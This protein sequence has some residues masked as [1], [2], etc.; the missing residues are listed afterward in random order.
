MKMRLKLLVKHC[1]WFVPLGLAVFVLWSDRHIETC[2]GT[3]TYTTVEALPEK[4]VA[5][6]LGTA[7]TYHG[8]GNLFYSA[9][10]KAA[11][12]LYTCGKVRGIL[13]SGDNGRKEYNEPLTMKQDLIL[14]GVPGEYITC[15]YAGFRTLDSIIRAEKVF[16]ITNYIIVSQPFHVKRA[17]YI[18][19]AM[20]HTAVGFCAKDVRGGWGT[21]ARL[22]EYLARTMCMLDIHLLKTRPKYLGEA[23]P[24]PVRPED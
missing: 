3:W 11:Q 15:D 23:V 18:A 7:K 2:A 13:V 5:L 22:R 1:F 20:G 19:R 9:R 4:P 14:M 12:K 8:Y 16:G 6:V 21:K 17:V 10:L 24:V